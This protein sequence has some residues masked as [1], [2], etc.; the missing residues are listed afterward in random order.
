[1]IKS[2]WYGNTSIQLIINEIGNVSFQI[3]GNR[4]SA[5]RNN[6][7]DAL[8]EYGVGHESA[9]EIVRLFVKEKL[10][11]IKVKLLKENFKGYDYRKLKEEDE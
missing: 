10:P 8:S 3:S 7:Y 9:K 2:Y 11:E 6:L 1:M 4:P 5:T